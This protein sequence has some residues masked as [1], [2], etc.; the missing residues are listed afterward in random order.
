MAIKR[1]FQYSTL[2][3]IRK[4][5][6]DIKAMVL[7]EARRR[8][9]AA[10]E[11]RE[12]LLEEQRRTLAHAGEASRHEFDASEVRRYYQYERH[13]ARL[14]VTKDAEIRQLEA[15]AEGKRADLEEATKRKRIMEKLKD[16][17]RTAFQAHFQKMEQRSLD[18][19]ATNYAA[20]GI[21]PRRVE[22]ARKKEQRK[23]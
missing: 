18:E 1:T 8:V 21:V 12:S 16:R 5:Q 11:Q 6:E 3:R 17:H 15:V 19:A 23:P 2:L 9:R 20:I 10:Q 4:R 7:A 22:A 13:L 14:A